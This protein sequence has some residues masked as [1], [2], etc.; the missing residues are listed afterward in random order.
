MNSERILLSACCLLACAVS[1]S[2]HA[3]TESAATGIIEEI[4]VTGTDQSRYRSDSTRSLSGINLGFMELP[5]VVEI[6]PEQILLDQ[7]VTELEE[8]LRNVPGITFSDGFGGSNNDFLIRGFRRNTVYRNGLRVR[9]N[10]RVNTSNLERVDIVKGPASITYGQVEPGGLVDIVT[11]KPLD[12]QRVYLEGRLGSYD[13]QFFLADWSQPVGQR[14]AFRVNASTEQSDT[15]RD[16]FDV[17]RDTIALTGRFDLSDKTTL[18]ADYEYR[19]EFRTFDRGTVT[20]PVPGG[21]AIAH[22]L[23]DLDPSTRFGEP[24]EEIDTEFEFGSLQ[25]EHVFNDAW[26][27]SLRL[28]KESSLSNDFQARPLAV[29]VFDEAAAITEDGFFTGPAQPEAAFDEASDQVFLA[30][31][32]DGSRD[33]DIEA[34]YAQLQFNGEFTTG[35][36]RHQVAV[37]ADYRSADESRFFVFNPPTNG[38]PVADGGTGPLLNLR[39]PEFGNLAIDTAAETRL[40][41]QSESDDY[42]FYVN[43]YIGLG[44]RV[45]LLVG[46]RYDISDPDGSGPADEVTEVS[47]QVA[48]N[49]RVNEQVVLFTS[50]SEAF[51]PNTAFALDAQGNPS[52]TELFDPEDSR[53]YE[54]GAKA[55]FFDRRLNFTASAYEIEKSNV[56]TVIDD[57]PQLVDGQRSQGVELSIGGQ[58][59]D[60]FNIVAGYAYTD[61]E[62]LTGANRGNRPQN[63]AKHTANLWASYEFSQGRLT[64]LGAGIGAFHLGDRFGSDANTWELDSYTLFDASIWYTLSTSPIRSESSLRLQLSVRN[65][66]DEE[67][68]PASGADL[69]INVGTPRTVV[70]SASLS[71]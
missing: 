28:A 61:A 20:V 51:E 45:G 19:D 31:R 57:T 35:K 3:Q 37:G 8:A 60:G 30:R 42:G 29:F 39:Q 24:F 71:F 12:D 41:F 27:A 65:L 11:K 25:L 64:G 68:Y 47:P 16:L 13:S 32:S 59:L 70:G 62:I 54:V 5:R 40:T 14:V 17:D 10:F 21:R 34:E 56:L 46:A 44:Q 18:T 7:K 4:T 48:L 26:S 66:A 63:A 1:T 2:V 55:Q 38:F 67:Y 23:L 49:Y 58:P 43:D 22:E 50:I 15:F 33:R 53:Q 69:R 52:G 6:I 36:I 9:S